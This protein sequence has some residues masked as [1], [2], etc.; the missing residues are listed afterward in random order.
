MKDRLLTSKFK[1]ARTMETILIESGKG[2]GKTIYFGSSQSSI[3][4]R[5]Y[6][7][8]HEQAGKGNDTDNQV[9][10]RT[11]VQARDD[12]A[13]KIAEMIMLSEEDEKTVG[14]IVAGILKYYLR[15]LVKG[16]DKNRSRW[17]TA[18]FWDKFLG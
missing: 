4:V 13:Q 16:K 2:E 18:P 1:K 11:E 7:K 8:N 6:E 3:Q 10:N 14:E 15:F 5:M 12:R 17:K 9:W